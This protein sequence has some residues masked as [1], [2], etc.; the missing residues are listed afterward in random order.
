MR[1]TITQKQL[2]Q[3]NNDLGCNLKSGH[4]ISYNTFRIYDISL[5]DILS[6]QVYYGIVDYFDKN[7]IKS[8]IYFD[9]E[10]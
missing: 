8:D 4:C 7:K 9:V 3:I 2:N 10:S 5:P 6:D 1:I